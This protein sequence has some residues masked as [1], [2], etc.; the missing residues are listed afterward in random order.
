MYMYT[1]SVICMYTYSV[2][3]RSFLTRHIWLGVN[4]TSKSSGEVKL[5]LHHVACTCSCRAEEI[6][7]QLRSLSGK[8]VVFVAA[9]GSHSAAITE[10]GALYTWGKGSY[11][12]LG[13]GEQASG[14]HLL[15]YT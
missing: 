12:R 6:P 15:V 4:L 14:P 3:C 2:I 5:V 13:H 9:G 1:Y 10:D 11:G 8:N 7:T